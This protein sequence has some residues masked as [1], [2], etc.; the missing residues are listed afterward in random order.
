MHLLFN[1]FLR[2]IK[3]KT[4]VSVSSQVVIYILWIFSATTTGFSFLIFAAASAL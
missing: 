4:K 2:Y 3:I 1:V